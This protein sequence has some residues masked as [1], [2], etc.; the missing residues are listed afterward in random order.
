MCRF[1]RKD[2]SSNFLAVVCI[3]YLPKP[4]NR[5]RKWRTVI[6]INISQEIVQLSIARKTSGLLYQKN[7][8]GIIL[9]S[10][11]KEASLFHPPQCKG[12]NIFF[13]NVTSLNKNVSMLQEGYLWYLPSILMV[14]WILLPTKTKQQ[15][16]RIREKHYHLH[17][18]RDGTVEQSQEDLWTALSKLYP[19]FNILDVIE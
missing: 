18:S 13:D 7:P 8:C 10:R 11:Q 16:L 5:I 12:M 9:L 19:A 6:N 3:L 17:L 4:N 2:T 1:S 15:E 14:I